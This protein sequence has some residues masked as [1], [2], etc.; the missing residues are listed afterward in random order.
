MYFQVIYYLI[1][2]SRQP[3]GICCRKCE[4]HC[5]QSIPIRDKLRELF[6]RDEVLVEK[7]TKHKELAQINVVPMLRSVEWAE[8]ENLITRIFGFVRAVYQ[9]KSR[10]TEIP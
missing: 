9:P 3:L 4:Q 6:A 10:K 7:R 2:V 1:Q 8:A 5:P